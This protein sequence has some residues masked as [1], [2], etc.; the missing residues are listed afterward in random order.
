[1]RVPFRD[2]QQYNEKVT[3]LSTR[4]IVS[5]VSPSSVPLR[6]VSKLVDNYTAEV[7]SEVNL[8]PEKMKSLA[9]ILPDSARSLN[10][11]LYRALDVYF[12]VGG[13]PT[14]NFYMPML[15]PSQQAPHPGGSCV[16]VPGK[17]NQQQPI[18][19]TQQQRNSWN[20]SQQQR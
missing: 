3:V 6:K 1:M 10:N 13:C 4:T 7:A 17:Q 19:H 9:E 11:G 16:D 15:S 5:E 20:L 2:H 14:P 18:L 12:K 8:K